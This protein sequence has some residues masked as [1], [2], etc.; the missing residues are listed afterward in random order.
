MPEMPRTVA[1]HFY[2]AMARRDHAAMGALYADD[3]TFTDPAFGTLNAAEARAM[4]RMLMTRAAD[5]SVTATVLEADAAQART[6]WVA[7][8][9]FGK[10]GRKVENDIMAT[11]TVR[12]GK[13][14]S[15]ADDFDMG[16]WMKQALGLPA[17]LLGWLPSFR[18]KVSTGAKAQLTAFMA[19]E[20]SGA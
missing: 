8:Y 12:D 16:R 1:E 15:H 13:I 3:A 4:W 19:K 6:R 7:R 2:A 14:T 5:F 18:N 17:V 9:T 11:M 20:K 10:T